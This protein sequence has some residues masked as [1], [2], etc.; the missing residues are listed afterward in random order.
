MSRE[1]VRR[2]LVAYDVTDDNRRAKLAKVLSRYGDRVQYSV[3]IVDTTPGKLIQM[4]IQIRRTVDHTCDSLL[5]CDLGPV[6]SLSP[7]QFECEGRQRAVTS[8]D[9][10]VV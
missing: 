8:S 2:T 1:D 5:F 10:F 4:R 3:F 9:S 7:G 6:G